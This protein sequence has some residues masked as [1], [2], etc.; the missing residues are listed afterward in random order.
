MSLSP[1]VIN[2]SGGSWTLVLTTRSN[3]SGDA[4]I[5]WDATGQ[6]EAEFHAGFTSPA[7]ALEVVLGRLDKNG[8]LSMP[9]VPALVGVLTGYFQ[10]RG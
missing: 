9:D 4:K 10:R 1:D 2:L 8:A 6:H 7:A 3:G 5:T